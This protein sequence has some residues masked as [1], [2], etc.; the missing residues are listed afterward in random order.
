MLLQSNLFFSISFQFF[1]EHSRFVHGITLDNCTNQRK[2]IFPNKIN[3]AFDN[4]DTEITTN[5][6]MSIFTPKNNNQKKKIV[7]AWLP[8][9]IL[10]DC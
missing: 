3:N 5:D 1:R 7:Q 10:M 9:Q 2:C 6:M 8:I 4:V